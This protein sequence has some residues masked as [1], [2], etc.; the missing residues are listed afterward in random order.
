[1]RNKSQYSMI[2]HLNLKNRRSNGIIPLS[3]NHVALSITVLLWMFRRWCQNRW[4][5]S[6]I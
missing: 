1:M 6:P 2:I 3:Q 4:I 5:S